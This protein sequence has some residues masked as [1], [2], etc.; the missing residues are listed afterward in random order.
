MADPTLLLALACAAR[1]SGLPNLP[2][3]LPYYERRAASA[4]ERAHSD[5]PLSAVGVYWP[6]A[7]GVIV[8][9]DWPTLVHEAVH[10]LQRLHDLPLEEGAAYAAQRR[11]GECLN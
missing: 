3:P 2:A 10:H 5:A 7:E 9:P 6:Y 1:L 4:Y 11:A 8:A